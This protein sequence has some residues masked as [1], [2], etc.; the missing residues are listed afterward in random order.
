MIKLLKDAVEA[1]PLIKTHFSHKL[2]KSQGS[3]MEFDNP[4]TGERIHATADLIIGA[5]GAYSALREQMSR[6]IK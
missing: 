1:C 2:A 4:V 5:D 3:Q 6:V